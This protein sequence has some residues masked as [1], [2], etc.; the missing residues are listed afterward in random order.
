MSYRPV[1]NSAQI[2]RGPGQDVFLCL[3]RDYSSHFA[4]YRIKRIVGEFEL[5][6]QGHE[7]ST[8]CGLHLAG[9]AQGSLGFSR[10]SAKKLSCKL[11][12]SDFPIH[13]DQRSQDHI[14]VRHTH[15]LPNICRSCQAYLHAC[16]I[17]TDSVPG[18]LGP[19]LAQHTTHR[20]SHQA[21]VSQQHGRP[22]V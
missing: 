11:G 19:W 8:F 22:A 7:L 4:I 15:S 9:T 20:H 10:Y 3:Q 18:W 12:C 1:H 5:A 17:N 16:G 21:R 2:N 6:A 14:A 13:N